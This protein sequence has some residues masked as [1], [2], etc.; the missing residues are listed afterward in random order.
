MLTNQRSTTVTLGT[1][2]HLG[3]CC[4]K[5][6]RLRT[7]RTGSHFWD[8]GGLILGSTSDFSG[9]SKFWNEFMI[10]YAVCM[11][12]L[13]TFTS[14][15]CVQTANIKISCVF[16]DSFWNQFLTA[17]SQTIWSF[18]DWTSARMLTT[19]STEHI[20]STHQIIKYIFDTWRNHINNDSNFFKVVFYPGD[21]KV[22]LVTL[23]WPAG[24]ARETPTGISYIYIYVNMGHTTIFWV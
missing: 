22:G 23:R 11:I 24:Y 3:W 6:R 10:K 14:V 16:S 19:L 1:F 21:Q 7:W 20:V 9:S 4:R 13:Y 5:R 12:L 18:K 15:S 2:E 17:D 8:S